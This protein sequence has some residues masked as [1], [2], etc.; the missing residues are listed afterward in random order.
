MNETKKILQQEEQR[1]YYWDTEGKSGVIDPHLWNDWV[2]IA[3]ETKGFMGKNESETLGAALYELGYA[4]KIPLKLE[5]RFNQF[6]HQR[7]KGL[8]EE[9]DQEKITYYESLIEETANILDQIRTMVR[10]LP[11]EETSERSRYGDESL[12][13]RLGKVKTESLEYQA[14]QE[15]MKELV[16]RLKLVTTKVGKFFY[17]G[18]FQ[19]FGENEGD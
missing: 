13:P 15:E 4:V 17:H 5:D 8:I 1:E 2:K 3:R 11:S 6:P 12:P 19:F 10:T 18:G 16:R 7:P 9:K 14:K